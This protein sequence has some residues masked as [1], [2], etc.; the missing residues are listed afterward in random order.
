MLK[1]IYTT[2]PTTKPDTIGCCRDPVEML[3]CEG[4]DR[5]RKFQSCEIFTSTERTNRLN[6]R[7]LWSDSNLRTTHPG[8]SAQPEVAAPDDESEHLLSRPSRSGLSGSCSTAG[9]DGCG[10]IDGRRARPTWRR[11][12]SACAGPG[13]GFAVIDVAAVEVVSFGRRGVAHPRSAGRPGA[14]P[15]P[16][17]PRPIPF[18]QTLRVGRTGPPNRRAVCRVNVR[19]A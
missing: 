3:F 13:I 2:V 12:A 19:R 6:K 18:G 8:V 17:P 1:F 5:K 7:N 16:A 9:R 4:F 11:R 10:D 15:A 14:V